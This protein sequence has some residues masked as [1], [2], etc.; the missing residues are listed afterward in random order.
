MLTSSVAASVLHHMRVSTMPRL[1]PHPRLIKTRSE[2]KWKKNAATVRDLRRRM[3]PRT[4]MKI[5]EKDEHVTAKT[6]AAQ[7]PNTASHANAENTSSTTVDPTGRANAENR[8]PHEHR[9]RRPRERRNNK[10]H[11]R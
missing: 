9:P 7:T 4:V 11:E 1:I 10:P 5:N 6:A 3:N 2:G 8:K